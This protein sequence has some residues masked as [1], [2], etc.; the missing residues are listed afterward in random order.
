MNIFQIAD[1][2]RALHK[3]NHPGLHREQPPF[4]ISACQLL[5]ADGSVVLDAELIRA[6]DAAGVAAF[7]KLL[8]VGGLGY[9]TGTG[10]AVTQITSSATAVTL[11]TYSGVITTVAL[12]TAAGAE[13]V[14]TVNDTLIGANDTISFGTTYAGAGTPMV[15]SKKIVAG[16]SFD[17]VVTNL[18]ASAALNALMVINFTITKGAAA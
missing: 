5:G 16:T 7:L 15:S 3:T 6:G 1:A 9:P 17:I 18:H 14:F 2:Y 13:E 12:S 8:A 11:N 10:G 4:A